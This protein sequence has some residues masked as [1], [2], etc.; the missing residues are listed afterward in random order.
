L[1]RRAGERPREQWSQATAD[2]VAAVLERYE[3]QVRKLIASCGDMQLYTSVA[4]EMEE[5]RR[6]CVGRP[7]LSLPWV[8][9][10]IAHAELVHRLWDGARAAST[11]TWADRQRQL[12]KVIIPVQELKLCCL[13]L[14]RP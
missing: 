6:C 2:H 13:R 12:E 5:I 14:A 4:E 1:P 8:M 9:L 7:E 11:V 10:L 3:M